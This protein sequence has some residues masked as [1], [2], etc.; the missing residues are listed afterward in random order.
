MPTF[1]LIHGLHI[2][3]CEVVIAASEGNIGVG[4]ISAVSTPEDED[5]ALIIV[6]I[7]LCVRGYSTEKGYKKQ[8]FFHV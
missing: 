1:G 3:E 5:F 7:V 4:L 2:G 6:G 8:Y